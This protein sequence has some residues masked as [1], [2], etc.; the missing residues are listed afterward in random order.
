MGDDYQT[1]SSGFLVFEPTQQ[2]QCVSLGI[3]DDR[4]LEE[5]FE[6]L[7]VLLDSNDSDVM[8]ALSEAVVFI[9]DDDSM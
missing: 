6:R 3:V 2:V 9:M 5:E 4:I 8:L 7:A 1:F